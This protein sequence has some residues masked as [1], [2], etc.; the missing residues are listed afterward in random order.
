MAGHDTRRLVR[1]A[2]TSTLCPSLPAHA[3]KC[4]YKRKH[5]ERLLT[6]ALQI[7]L[8]YCHTLLVAETGR[9]S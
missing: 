2:G 4:N 7:L 6:I 8:S 3:Q 9:I 1:N 5:D